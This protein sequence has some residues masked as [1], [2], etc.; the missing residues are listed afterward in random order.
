MEPGVFLYLGL[1]VLLVSWILSAIKLWKD[2]VK[3]KDTLNWTMLIGI[4]GALMFGFA[5]YFTVAI[6]EVSSEVSMVI[7]IVAGV[8]YG[9]FGGIAMGGLFRS[10][11]IW[12]FGK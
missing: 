1:G 8:L 3:N 7:G 11:K 9:L 4:T 10:V 2:K 12:I 6:A 5:G